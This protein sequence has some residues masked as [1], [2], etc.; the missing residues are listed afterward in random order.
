MVKKSA[1]R[2]INPDGKENHKMSAKGKQFCNQ[3]HHT[4]NRNTCKSLS[5]FKLKNHFF[6]QK[7][8]QNS[9]KK[10]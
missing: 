6:M 7:I 5:C 2:G 8:G 3:C 4:Q 1:V 10:A 9:G